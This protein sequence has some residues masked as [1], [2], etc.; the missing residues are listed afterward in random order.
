MLALSSTSGCPGAGLLVTKKATEFQ[1]IFTTFAA[2][3]FVTGLGQMLDCR[4]F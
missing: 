2:G 1:V 3:D 4:F